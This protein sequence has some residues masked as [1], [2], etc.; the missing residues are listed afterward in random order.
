MSVTN[1][2]LPPGYRGRLAPTPSGYLHLGHVRTFWVAAQRCRENDGVLIL[3]NEDLDRERCKEQFAEAAMEDLRWLGCHW[4]EGPDI[5]GP[6]G[7][8]NQ[9]ERMDFYLSIWRA[10]H[11][12]G[13]I[14]PSPHSRRDVRRALSAPHEED[15]E[16]LFPLELRPPE[17]TGCDETE[18]G[19]MN[20][21][22]RVPDG[23]TISFTD[24]RAGLVELEAGKD[25]GDFLVWRKDG[26]P[27]YEMAVTADDH[28]MGITE[29]VRGEDLLTSTARQLLIYQQLG[30]I[31]PAFYH[32]PLVRD[33]RGAP[34]S[35]RYQS[36][37]TGPLREIGCPPEQLFAKWEGDSGLELIEQD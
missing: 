3:R 37:R 10:L 31:P 30:W 28:G 4:Q 7:P 36:S 34:L 35:K 11:E 17:R 33:S 23:K 20:W 12:R 2:S 16:P 8:Y 9:S 15:K 26:Y 14:Y 24:G 22:F 27:S 21:R 5:D 13:A 25:F 18:P 19:S 29:V 32:C 6:A 1:A